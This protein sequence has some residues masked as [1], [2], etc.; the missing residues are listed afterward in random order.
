MRRSSRLIRERL[1]LSRRDAR[2]LAGVMLVGLAIRVAYVLLTL[3]QP[4]RGDAPE[5][6]LQG[7][8]LTDGKWF[9]STTPYGIAH[10]SLW[11][12]PGYVAWVGGWYALRGAPDPDVVRLAQA[13]IGPLVIGLTFLLGRRLFSPAAG[14]MAAAIVAV[15]P[16]VWQFEVLLYSEALAI[17]L[18][19]GVLLLLLDRRPT[20]RHAVL[21]GVLMGAGLLIRPSAGFLFAGVAVSWILIGG[22][23]RGAAMTAVAVVVAGLCVAPWTYRNYQVDGGFVP[24][25]VQDAA[26]FGTFNNDAASDPAHPY[27]WRP[28]N[29]RD[30]PLFDPQRPLSD[31][32]LRNELIKRSRAYIRDNPAS[33]PEAFFWNGLSR[34]WDVRRPA[35]PLG[36]VRFEGRSR[37]LAAVGLGMYWLLLVLALVSLWRLRGRREIVLPVLALA[38]AA[39]IVFTA[40]AGTRYRAPLEPL[41]VV[42]ACSTPA[43][44]RIGRR[45]RRD[46]GSADASPDQGSDDAA[47]TPSAVAP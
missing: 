2:F 28:S 13:F 22:L 47:E 27:V 3:D 37:T 39:S 18:T 1:G 12:A 31:T 7:S 42:L 6:H 43:V 44:E 40:D 14:L 33:L 20:A 25:S 38:L 8:F 36:E 4:L 32:E 5:Y 26:L 46:D 34:L 11:K 45:L 15:Y 10:P 21:V 24:I 23:R 41:I 17:P 16:F 9:W 29:T 19:L 35:H 30:A